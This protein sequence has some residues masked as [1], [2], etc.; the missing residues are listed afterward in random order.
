[1]KIS[2]ALVSTV[3]IMLCCGTVSQVNAATFSPVGLGFSSSA[4]ATITMKSPAS[5]G[6]EVTCGIQLFATG[7]PDGSA[8]DINSVNLSGTSALCSQAQMGSLPWVLTPTSA[9]TAVLTRVDYRVSG[10]ILF[11]ATNCGPSSINVHMSNGAGG[12]NATASNQWLAGNCT[13]VSLNF[14]AFPLIIVP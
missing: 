4:N 6:A 2:N 10:S 1:M 9:T 14:T 5:W 3:L 12:F 11:P 8:L 7:R 13:V